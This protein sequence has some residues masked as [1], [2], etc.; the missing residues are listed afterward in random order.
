MSVCLFSSRTHIM[1]SAHTFL[2]FSSNM[3][4]WRCQ[5]EC[6]LHTVHR[7][8]VLSFQDSAAFHHSLTSLTR[9]SLL[10]LSDN[11]LPLLRACGAQRGQQKPQKPECH[12]RLW[13][14][15]PGD[16]KNAKTM[17]KR[18]LCGEFLIELHPEWIQTV[19]DMK[20]SVYSHV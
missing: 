9:R 15:S 19:S 5:T 4:R 11:Y 13:K 2:V 17:L 16:E 8:R 10:A 6:Q 3:K 18:Q 7:E 1:N 12:R 20:N 14:A